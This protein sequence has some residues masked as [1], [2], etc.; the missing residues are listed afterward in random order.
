M[1][2]VTAVLVVGGLLITVFAGPLSSWSHRAAADLVDPSAY[3]RAVLDGGA[4]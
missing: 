2:S 3:R 4:R 1:Q